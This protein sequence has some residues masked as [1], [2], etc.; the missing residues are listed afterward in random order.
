[1]SR[2]EYPA[3]R[4]MQW[5]AGGVAL[6]RVKAWCGQAIL[7][8]VGWVLA[9]GELKGGFSDRAACVT[10]SGLGASAARR[11]LGSGRCER[12]LGCGGGG[13]R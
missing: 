4:P 8:W 10:E 7:C 5:D 6:R 11:C 2:P 3:P 9:G 13:S 12:R 1:V